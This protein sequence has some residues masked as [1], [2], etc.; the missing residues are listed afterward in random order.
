MR[1]RSE[2]SLRPRGAY[3]P[4]GC[5]RSEIRRWRSPSPVA[6]LVLIMLTFTAPVVL[7]AEEA[8]TITVSKGDKI[9]LNISTLSGGEGAAATK[10]LQNDLTLSGYF[11]LSGN[12]AYTARGSAS[13]G[14]LQGQVVDHSGGI[15]LAKNYSGNARETAHK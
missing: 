12:A 15:V 2:V 5:Q 11:I 1:R 14:S 8:P 9:N 10:T 7:G 4:A 13:G 6:A 3:A